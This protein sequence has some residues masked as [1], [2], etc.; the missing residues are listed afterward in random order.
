MENSSKKTITAILDAAGVHVGPNPD[1]PWDMVV[2]DERFYDRALRDNSIGIGEA[3]ME[4]WWDV[5]RLDELAAKVLSSS[6]F[7]KLPRDPSAFVALI[8]AKLW[9]SGAKNKAFEVGQHHYDIGNDLFE[10]MLDKRL[11]YTCAYWQH[12][13]KDLDEAQEHKLDLVCRKIGLDNRPGQTVLDIGCGWGSF[14][15]FAAERYGAVV[16]GITVSKEQA[17]LAVQLCKGLPVTIK[18]QDYRD[19]TEKFDHVISLGM[20]EHV[21]WKNYRTYME[22]AHRVLKDDGYFLLHTIAHDRTTQTFEPWLGKYIFPNSHVPSYRQVAV[23]AENLFALEDWHSFGPD[24]DKTLMAWHRNFS[25]GWESL[26]ATGKYDERFRRMWSYYLLGLAGAFR[27]R[28]NQLWQVVFSKLGNTA[29][30]V[31]VR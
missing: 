6:A 16:T 22:V 25:A 9:N 8:R 15:K 29:P 4:G 11:V 7:E 3:Y 24:Y 1:R 31:S 13:A 17:E 14:A 12:G 2:H 10:K 20:F 5:E 28:R 26:K 18:L 19:V 27:V 21:G 30:Y 23:A